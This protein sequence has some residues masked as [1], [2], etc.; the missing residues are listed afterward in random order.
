MHDPFYMYA[1]LFYLSMKN[2]HDQFTR[3]PPTKEPRSTAQDC[4]RLAP[5]HPTPQAAA[6]FGSA[7]WS[8]QIPAGQPQFISVS[9]ANHQIKQPGFLNPPVNNLKITS[10][11]HK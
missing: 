11:R 9:V 5:L 1:I 7:F 8:A 2:P 4:R 6:D 10:H 3:G